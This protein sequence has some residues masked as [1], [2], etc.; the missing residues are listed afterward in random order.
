MTADRCWQPL[1]HLHIHYLKWNLNKI[2]W[3]LKAEKLIRTV[4]YN[5]TQ[6]ELNG[7]C[8]EKPEYLASSTIEYRTSSFASP[9][10]Q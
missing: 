8:S 4:M 6:V 1:H 9:E 5:F 2:R 3:T 10:S 7:I